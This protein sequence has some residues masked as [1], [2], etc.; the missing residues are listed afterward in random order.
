MKM[1]MQV[2]SRKDMKDDVR[3]RK[4]EKIMPVNEN[5]STR[6]MVSGRFAFRKPAERSEFISDSAKIWELE[7]QQ[8]HQ[9]WEE[10]EQEEE[11]YSPQ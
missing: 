8:E 6:V 3:M 1:R 10:E 7:D 11:I 9:E 2:Q 4:I 5:L